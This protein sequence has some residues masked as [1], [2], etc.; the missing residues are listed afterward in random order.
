MTDHALV[1]PQLIGLID[2]LF[3][4]ASIVTSRLSSGS[5]TAP[6]ALC[7]NLLSLPI[8]LVGFYVLLQNLFTQ[9]YILTNVHFTRG[10]SADFVMKQNVTKR[11]C[12]LLRLP[13]A[14][15]LVVLS[16]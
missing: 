2:P 12:P 11:W 7:W 14:T 6:R 13:C 8:C 4:V 5:C 16:S 10:G 3:L 9:P 1:L 15:G